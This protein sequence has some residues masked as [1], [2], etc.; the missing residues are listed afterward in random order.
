MRTRRVALACA[1]VLLVLVLALAA[2]GS[3]SLAGTSWE[4]VVGLTAVTV[5]FDSADQYTSDQFGN[6]TYSID[7]NQVTLEPS[8]QGQTRVFMIDGSLMQGTVDGW[9]CTLTRQ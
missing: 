9:P 1:L 4:G 7:G 5:S 8:G 2:C 6:G 3:T